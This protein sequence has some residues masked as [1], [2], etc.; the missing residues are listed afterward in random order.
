MTNTLKNHF[1]DGDYLG[2]VGSYSGLVYLSGQWHKYECGPCMRSMSLLKNRLSNGDHPRIL[3]NF[4][5]M[6]FEYRH[7]AASH[8]KFIAEKNK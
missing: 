8:K 4:Q 6:P 2:I 1:S 5:N 7:D 3:K